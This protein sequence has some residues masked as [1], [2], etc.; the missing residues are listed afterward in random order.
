MVLVHHH[1]PHHP[2]K[3]F[4][5]HSGSAQGLLLAVSSGHSWHAWGT[6]KKP[7]S[8]ACKARAPACCAFSPTSAYFLHRR[9][10]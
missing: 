3:I 6:S 7:R 10:F 5:G 2:L 9:D 1:H 4:L 8:P